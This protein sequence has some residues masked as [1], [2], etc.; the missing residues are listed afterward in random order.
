MHLYTCFSVKLMNVFYR[1]EVFNIGFREQ[2][3]KELEE[4][5]TIKKKLQGLEV[6]LL[7]WFKADYKCLREDDNFSEDSRVVYISS[8]NKK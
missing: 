8:I 7:S 3:H 2:M 5:F 4:A 6:F 1:S